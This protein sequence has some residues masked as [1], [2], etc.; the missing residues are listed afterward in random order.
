MTRRRVQLDDELLELLADEPELLAIA[1]A[2]VETQTR[3]RRVRPVGLVAIGAGLAC[4]LVLVLALWPDGKSSGI[5]VDTAVAA[6]G[7]QARLVSVEIDDEAGAVSLSYDRS[8]GRMTVAGPAPSVSVSS[9][10]LPPAATAAVSGLSRRFG[11]GIGP[12]VSLVLE[13]PGL[14]KSGHVRS[15][16]A[17]PGRDPALR[18]VRY[19]SSLGYPVEVGLARGSLVPRVVLRPGATARARI[20]GVRLEG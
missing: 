8:L 12:A 11:A 5:A 3:R 18:W 19:E 4:L 9:A 17:P 1:D 7:G 20:R 15:I 6:I 2:I 14:V 10:Q 13:Y 16:P